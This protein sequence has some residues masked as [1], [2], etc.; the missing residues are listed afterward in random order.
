[1]ST[2]AQTTDPVAAFNSHLAHAKINALRLLQDLMTSLTD[3]DASVGAALREIRLAATAILRAQPIKHAAPPSPALPPPPPAERA[4]ARA[5]RSERTAPTT[6]CTDHSSDL[7]PPTPDAS[8]V[9]APPPPHP[10]YRHHLNPTFR[11]AR[12]DVRALIRA[13]VPEVIRLFLPSR[14]PPLSNTATTSPKYQTRPNPSGT[15]V[16]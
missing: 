11:A 9:D 8:R 1:M 7:S 5:Q 16:T 2:A 6:P 12:N 4:V 14:A 13:G 10:T 3:P 15:I